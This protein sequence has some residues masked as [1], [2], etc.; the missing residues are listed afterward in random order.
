MTST[1]HPATVGDL[2]MAGLEHLMRSKGQGRH[3]GVTVVRLNSVPDMHGLKS[4]W[5]ALFA[6]HPV[7]GARLHRNWRGWRLGWLAGPPLA[8][9]PVI[10]RPEVALSDALV[11]E[12]LSGYMDGQ[13][14]PMP[15]QMELLAARTLLLTWRHG[16]LDGVGINLLLEQ[17]A[18]GQIATAE[19]VPPPA[20]STPGQLYQQALPVINTLKDMTTL[21]SHSAW[22][23]SRPLGGEPGF[24]LIELS[25]AQSDAVAE[26]CRRT[27]GDFFQMPFFAAVAARALWR[28]HTLRGLALGGCH[29]EVPFQARKRAPGAVFQNR[30][31]MLLLPLLESE[32]STFSG[33]A[34]HVLAVYKDS[35]KRQLPKASEA[36]GALMMY[37]PSR[38]LMPIIRFQNR[39]E[40]CSLFHSHT[41]TFLRGV[42]CFA[43]AEVANVY[44]IPSVSTPPGFGLFFSDY[45]GSLTIT[46]AWRGESLNNE[47]LQVLCEQVLTDLT[48]S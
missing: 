28:L 40:I 25:S 15:L 19:P 17:L 42:E 46:M 30:M 18:C 6:E 13:P 7:L 1:F 37:L 43:G 4:A 48:A 29:M 12:R 45:R 20:E 39:G 33:A 16:I 35:V 44:T 2:F 21:G 24:H 38:A 31:G 9:P 27:C 22:D 41:G 5:K 10:E 23:R 11:R 26:T 32:M 3:F 14:N 34:A 47:E 8:A 36:L